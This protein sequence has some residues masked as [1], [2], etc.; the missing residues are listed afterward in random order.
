MITDFK[1]YKFATDQIEFH[2]TDGHKEI[3]FADGTKK[4]IN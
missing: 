4:Y 2:H 3:K 1:I